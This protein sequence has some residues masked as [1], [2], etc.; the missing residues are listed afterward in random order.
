MSVPEHPGPVAPWDKG[1]T[2]PPVHR[3]L[4]PPQAHTAVHGGPF[5][6][7]LPGDFNGGQN[8]FSHSVKL[9]NSASAN[10]HSNAGETCPEILTGHQLLLVQE[11][12][13]SWV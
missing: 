3:Q 9:W 10:P 2:E 11:V 4:Q 5:R 13:S 8:Q 7:P 6:Q 12:R 1:R